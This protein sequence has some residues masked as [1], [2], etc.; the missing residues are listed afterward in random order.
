MPTISPELKHLLLVT[1]CVY[2]AVMYALAFW[3]Q[4]RIKTEEDFLV[5]G[6]RLPLSLAWMTLLA[7]WFGAATLLTVAEEVRDEGVRAAALDP[8][9]AGVCL[10]LAGAFLAGPMWRQ[11]ILTIPDLFRQHYG[12]IA[13][14]I[15]SL[16]MIPSYFG[17][18][19]VQFTALA[20]MLHLFFQLPLSWGIVLVAAIGTGYTLMGGMWSVTLT[21]AVQITMVLVGLLVLGPVVVW[22]VGEGSFSSGMQRLINETPPSLL[23][24]IPRDSRSE[25]TDWLGLFAAGAFGNLVAQDLMQ[26]V[27]AARSERT[28]K[29]A[30]FIAGTAYLS[31]G[32][33]PIGLGL[34]S[35][36]LFPDS[37]GSVL[38]TLASSF[39]HPAL[40]VLF[41]VSI[42]SAVL[43]T[44]D[45][46][47]LSPA[48]ILSH[49]LLARVCRVNHLTLNRWAIV[50]I[51]SASV[52]LALLGEDAYRLLE[53]SYEMPFVGLLVPMLAAAWGCGERGRE[54]AALASMA[55]GIVIWG[56]HLM[57]GSEYFLD[58][59]AFFQR[60]QLPIGITAT[61]LSATVF[62]ILS[63]MSSRDSVPNVRQSE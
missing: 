30:C 44:I 54:A 15:C 8:F 13:E 62:G 25:F 60:W 28:A 41:T 50:V 51:A 22:H 23:T 12:P 5:A 56:A 20:G 31:F 45:S 10:L 58:H 53:L 16:I 19:A 1:F 55:A 36:M 6:R 27:F 42:L 46:A 9:G 7:T 4:G 49:N 33:I 39:L 26:R 17:W 37:T 24:V 35:R 48:S 61:L 11:K 29:Y 63:C 14:T 2:V 21:D 18:I 32:W 38:P 59:I 40:A 52:T 3:A 47:I 57:L 34:S 43:S